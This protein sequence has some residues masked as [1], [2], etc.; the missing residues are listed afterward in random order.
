MDNGTG[1]ALFL[2]L[3]VFFL[4]A[5]FVIFLIVRANRGSGWSTHSRGSGKRYSDRSS[6][7]DSYSGS[8]SSG[9]GSDYGG[10]SSEGDGASGDW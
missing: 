6:W 3:F 5:L 2:F 4:P 7:F 10:G 8:H 1:V 9:S